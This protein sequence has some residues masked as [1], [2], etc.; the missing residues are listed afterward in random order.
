[1]KKG[2][3]FEVWKKGEYLFGCTDAAK[4]F[5]RA[6]LEDADKV[7]QRWL[8]EDKGRRTKDFHLHGRPV[9]KVG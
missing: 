5:N 4:A 7:T 3:W 6:A 2:I 9:R 8:F 1:M